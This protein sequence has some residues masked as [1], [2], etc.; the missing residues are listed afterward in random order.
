[1]TVKKQG[2]FLVVAIVVMFVF[3][4]QQALST[5]WDDSGELLV[6][7]FALYGY[8]ALAMT[9]A[10]TPFLVGITQAFGKPFLR[11]HHIFSIFGIVFT[12]LHPITLAT[13]T[14]DITVFLP[15]FDSWEI[16]WSL[17]VDLPLSFSTWH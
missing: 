13:R 14:L 5:L 10:M 15:S 7:L 8:M 6:R 2:Y 3:S 12:T 11:V 4:T 16:F 9:T 1:M 17:A